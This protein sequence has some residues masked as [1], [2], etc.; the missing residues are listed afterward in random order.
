MQE[1]FYIIFNLRCV[2]RRPTQW[3]K[4]IKVKYT[5][6]IVNAEIAK[7]E[8]QIS[9]ENKK[10]TG[11]ITINYSKAVIWSKIGRSRFRPWNILRSNKNPASR[12]SVHKHQT[13]TQNHCSRHLCSIQYSLSNTVDGKK[14]ADCRLSGVFYVP[15]W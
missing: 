4:T 3:P 14:G 13:P 6:V 15:F 1:K 9:Y 5:K 11:N 2:L 12:Q 10:I 7:K 8:F